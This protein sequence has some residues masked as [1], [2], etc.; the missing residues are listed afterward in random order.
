MMMI[1][2]ISAS[3]GMNCFKRYVKCDEKESL[4]MMKNDKDNSICNSIL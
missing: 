3:K 4:R 2:L 1:I